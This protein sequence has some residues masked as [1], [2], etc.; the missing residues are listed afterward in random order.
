MHSCGDCRFYM[1]QVEDHWH[2]LEVV[3]GGV[4]KFDAPLHNALR[5]SMLFSAILGKLLFDYH[6]LN[7]TWMKFAKARV[8]KWCFSNDDN[9]DQNVKLLDFLKFEFQI[10]PKSF[11][12]WWSP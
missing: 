10:F 9:G 12:L 3:W 6:A 5:G 1:H 7:E 11:F 8:R 4:S 2:A